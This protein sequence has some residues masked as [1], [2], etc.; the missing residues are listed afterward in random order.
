M[1]LGWISCNSAISSRINPGDINQLKIGQAIRIRFSAF[2]QADAPKARGS[3]F[4]I[5]T[6]ALKDE[7]TGESYFKT[8]VK[9]NDQQSDEVAAL[10]L[11]PGMPADLFVNKGERTVI[12]YLAQPVS[13]RLARTFIE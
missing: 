9:L 12:A 1:K 11:A 6:D 5:S 7:R 3:L 10:D 8:R 2:A 13:E 4:D